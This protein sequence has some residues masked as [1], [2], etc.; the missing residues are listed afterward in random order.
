MQPLEKA[1]IAAFREVRFVL[2][3]MD[4]TLTYNGRLSAQT[5]AALETLQSAGVIVIPVTAA[6]AGWCDQMARMWP[7]DGVIGEN[8]GFF[9]RRGKNAH[10]LERHFWHAV[11]DRAAKTARLEAIGEEVLQTVPAAVFAEDQPFR[12]TSL[13]FAQPHDR[14]ER[15]LILEALRSRSADATVNNLWVLGWLGGYDKLSMARRVLLEHYGLD[16]DT[17]RGAVLYTGDSTNDAPMF[18]FFEHTVGVCTITK[19]L[20]D[21]PRLPRW[22]T[23]G[24]GGSGFIEAAEA[25]IASR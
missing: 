6:P 22:I 24:P 15:E 14:T 10:V 20:D 9:F 18:S 7:V 17:E 1:D 25:V 19:Y 11:D 8:G 3:D 5:Y 2:T 21:L 16:V 4:E 23:N 13:A 12:L